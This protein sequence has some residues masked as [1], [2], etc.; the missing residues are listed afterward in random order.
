MAQRR[1][2]R[3]AAY[4]QYNLIEPSVALPGPFI[5]RLRAIAGNVGNQASRLHGKLA[6]PDNDS[7][8]RKPKARPKD[9]GAIRVDLPERR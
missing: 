9:G 5:R 6:R 8:L 4:R 2:K 1:V 3:Q 7:G